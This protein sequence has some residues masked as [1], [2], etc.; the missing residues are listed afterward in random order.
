LTGDALVKYRDAMKRTVEAFEHLGNK[1]LKVEQ[2]GLGIQS[3]DTNAPNRF[4][5]NA[6]GPAKMQIDIC[7]D[8]KLTVTGADKMTE[9]ELTD[10]ISKLIDTAKDSGASVGGQNSAA[11]M[12]ARIYG[13]SMAST[14]VTFVL[15]DIAELRE[16]ARKKAFK[17][18]ETRAKQLAE[19]SGVKLGPVISIEETLETTPTNERQKI[20]ASI[21]GWGDDEEDSSKKSEGRVMSEKL[22]D[23]PVRVSLR[24]RFSIKEG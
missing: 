1:N 5:G 12:R 3:M 19:L 10:M 13:E 17:Q 4:N 14:V 2:R 23:I 21:Y 22:G 15:D 7:G 16:Q 8:L 20:L 24:V 9:E 6:G 18:A 11:S